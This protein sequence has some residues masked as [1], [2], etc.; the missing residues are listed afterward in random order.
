M[1]NKDV[2]DFSEN[3]R[4]I[5]LNEPLNL[6]DIIETEV[7]TP[8]HAAN[9]QLW[10]VN[11]FKLNNSNE[12]V[13]ILTIHHGLADGKNAN[14]LLVEYM[15]ILQEFLLGKSILDAEEYEI[16]LSLEDL[17]LSQ[18]DSL[19]YVPNDLERSFFNKMLTPRH[20]KVE[21]N[22]QSETHGKFEFFK[23][24]SSKLEKLISKMK[25]LVPQTK[26]TSVLACIICLAIKYSLSKLYS[27]KKEEKTA[28]KMQ[29]FIMTK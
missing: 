13:F 7:K 20:L 26:L 10:R 1:E 17:M 15:K 6:V 25:N 16:K 3:V 29:F 11:I 21:L 8:F 12:Y 28:I 2:G 22:A 14:A 5:E 23:I 18:K 19:N 27:L 9:S 24:D 4:F